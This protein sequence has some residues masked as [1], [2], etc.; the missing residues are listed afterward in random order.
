[1]CQDMLPILNLLL[2]IHMLLLQHLQMVILDVLNN[3][4]IF[5][6]FKKYNFIPLRPKPEPANTQPVVVSATILLIKENFD[7]FL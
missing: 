2:V 4:Y 1:M 7:F 6:V 3:I 5:E